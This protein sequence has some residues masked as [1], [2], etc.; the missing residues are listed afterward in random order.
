MPSS[1]HPDRRAFLQGAL[2]TV[3]GSVL[4]GGCSSDRPYD[5]AALMQPA[6]LQTLGAARVREIGH[7][8]LRATPAESADVTLREA[9]AQRARRLRRLP[10]SPYPS[11]DTLIAA[12]FA[13]DRVVFPAG[14]MLSVNEARQCALFALQG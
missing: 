8:Y 10:W 6:L 4:V 12:D 9:I 5:E 1:S 14:W 11:L 7:A 3:A 2:C 13:E